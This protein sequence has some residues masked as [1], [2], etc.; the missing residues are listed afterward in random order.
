VPGICPQLLP[1]YF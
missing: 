1:D